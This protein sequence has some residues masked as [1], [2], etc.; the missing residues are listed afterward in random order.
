MMQTTMT[1]AAAAIVTLATHAP[2]QVS[3]FTTKAD[4]AAASDAAIV[5]T[6][7]E[8]EW[9]AYVGA[10]GAP[11]NASNGITFDGTPGGSSN[12]FV[13]PEGQ[14]N[15]GVPPLSRV[16]TESGNENI[17]LTFDVQTF[18]AG[19]EFYAN[20]NDPA[21]FI[22]ELSDG[23]TFTFVNPQ[24]PDT[25]GYVGFVSDTLPIERIN[26][27]AVGGAIINTGIDNV[28]TD[29]GKCFPDCNDDGNLDILDF[30]CFQTAFV[31]IQP[32]ADCDENGEFNILDFICF[33]AAFQAGCL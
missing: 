27:L 15:F 26:W 24:A 3:L 12:L 21:M 33:Q 30:V 18:S 11:F 6:F 31:A 23:S 5:V 16:L 4:F 1:V 7:E 17:D 22:V 29:W 2:A 25:V 8:P 14:L 10:A 20:G 9:D 32:L 13:A 28:A 19:F